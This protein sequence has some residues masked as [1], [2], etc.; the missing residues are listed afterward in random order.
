MRKDTKEYLDLVDS[1]NP[2]PSIAANT[3]EAELINS[4]PTSISDLSSRTRTRSSASK[5]PVLN[6]I[7]YLMFNAFF[8]GW[9]NRFMHHAYLTR[10]QIKIFPGIRKYIFHLTELNFCL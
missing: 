6:K 9:L 3:G 10:K 4:R 5:L 8:I 2:P 1:L 7:G